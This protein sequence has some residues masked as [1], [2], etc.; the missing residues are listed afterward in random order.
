MSLARGWFCT[1]PTTWHQQSLLASIFIR[2]SFPPGDNNADIKPENKGDRNKFC[3]TVAVQR[4]LLKFLL[5]DFN[6][7]NI[8]QLWFNNLEYLQIFLPPLWQSFYE[9]WPRW[10]GRRWI[11]TFK[12]S[13][14]LVLLLKFY[15]YR[16]LCNMFIQLTRPFS[17]RMRR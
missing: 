16:N 12:T 15:I 3:E 4:Y 13:C 10:H 14:K 6:R 9:I 7:L 11:S 8:V 5:K 2:S 1:D 17:L